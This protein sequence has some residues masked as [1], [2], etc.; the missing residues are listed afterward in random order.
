MDLVGRE[1]EVAGGDPGDLARRPGGGPGA[2]PALA[3][4]PRRGAASRA[5]AARGPRGTARA[6]RPADVST[7]SEQDQR[8]CVD[9][10]DRRAHGRR[11][12]LSCGP[13]GRGSRAR[14]VAAARRRRVRGRASAVRRA[15][16]GRPRTGSSRTAGGSPRCSSHARRAVAAGWTCPIP[17][18]R[19][20][21]SAG[22]SWRGPPTPPTARAGRRTW[23]HDRTPRDDSDDSWLR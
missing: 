11:R 10:C 19:R 4:R 9:P 7:S 6:D 17:A 21:E 23:S 13:G 16:R 5:G 8:R 12:A 3:G 14:D 15:C 18:R 20:Q 2:S 22:G 1:G